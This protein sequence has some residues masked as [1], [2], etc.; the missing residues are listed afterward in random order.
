MATIFTY[1]AGDPPQPTGQ[2]HLLFSARGRHFAG[3]HAIF[4][5]KEKRLAQLKVDLCERAIATLRGYG[6]HDKAVLK[7][8][9]C[10]ELRSLFHE[11]FG[12]WP[13]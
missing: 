1:Y 6:Y 3:W 5:E 4:K 12:H 8:L 7:I 13:R 10:N 11:R 9:E 2:R